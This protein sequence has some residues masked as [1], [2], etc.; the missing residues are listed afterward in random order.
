MRVI[1]SV[2]L[3]LLLSGCVVFLDHPDAELVQGVVVRSDN[4]KP[5]PHAEVM[6]WEG[7]RFFTLFPVSY[8]P[9]AKATADADGV[10]SIRVANRWPA[11]ITAHAGA[12]WGYVEPDH[13]GIRAVVL[14]LSEEKPVWR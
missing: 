13:A 3:A 14:R 9:A 6:V 1:C 7:R 4:G 5:V 2:F 8:P 11:R 10:F 12:L